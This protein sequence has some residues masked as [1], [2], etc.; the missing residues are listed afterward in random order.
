MPEKIEKFIERKKSECPKII[1]PKDIGRKTRL[2]FTI[3]QR[4][5]YQQ[6]NLPEKVFFIEKLRKGRVNKKKLAYPHAW[7]DGE[8][9]YRLGYYI[10][11]RIGSRRGKWTFGQYC[12]I[13][14]KKDLIKLIKKAK[15]EKTL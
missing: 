1:K 5:F 6:S 13:L 4:T 15:Q 7:K 11:G 2:I 8:I 14:P 9:E 3:E 12:P 10:I